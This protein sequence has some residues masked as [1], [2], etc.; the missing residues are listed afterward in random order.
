MERY[1]EN[2]FAIF[3]ISD[4]ILFFDYKPN[5]VIDLLSA[6]QIVADRIA[7][8]EGKAYP[9]LCD[10]RGII[11]SDKAA[12]NYLAQ[13][14]SILAKA[15]GIIAADQKS[16]SFLMISFYMKISRPQIPTKVFTNRVSALEFLKPF[17]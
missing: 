8:Q 6:Q 3:W 7:I 10:I 2:K 14:G 4:K 1:F 5:V 12:R 13:H 17:V 15:V 16:L 11:D 9:V